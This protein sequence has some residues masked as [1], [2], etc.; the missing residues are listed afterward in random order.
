MRNI[1]L[2]GNLSPSDL[3]HSPELFCAS[4]PTKEFFT[5]D[6]KLT[7]VHQELEEMIRE[8][9]EVDDLTN[10]GDEVTR[11]R[12]ALGDSGLLGI[13]DKLV[14]M[15]STVFVTASE[16]CGKARCILPSSGKERH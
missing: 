2:A 16:R 6:V 10:N 1:W 15:K 4:T 9:E 14:S 3:S 13:L 8:G 12:E 11:K 5:S 7:G